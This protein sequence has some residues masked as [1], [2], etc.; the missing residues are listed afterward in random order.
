MKPFI[1]KVSYLIIIVALL[2]IS[3][4]MLLP[5][6]KNYNT[7]MIEKL[8]LLRKNKDKKK[9]LL[10][11]GSSVGWGLSAEQIQNATNTITINLGHH[12]GYGLTDFQDYILSC[13]TANDLIILSPEWV[14]YSDPYYSD[15]ATLGDLSRNNRYLEL[16]NR[17][18]IGRI[19]PILSKEISFI[20][21]PDKND[22]YRY[23]CLNGNGD[24]VSHCGLEAKGPR[25]Y[26]IDSLN[27]NPTKFANAFKYISSARCILL[28]PP[29][30]ES[31]YLKN[32]SKLNKLQRIITASNLHYL[33]SIT[34]NIYRESDFYDAEYHLNCE[35]R[36]KRTEKIISYIINQESTLQ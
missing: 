28:F 18:W 32:Q 15:K 9:I 10:I 30:Q 5:Q 25:K 22:P 17:P 6:K 24:V 31:V 21:Q 13:L 27:F 16:T 19:K 11:G 7:A 12:A 33:D 14:F 2:S 3:I 34:E 35:V 26:S 36:T 8:E 29:T 20:K 1:A 4:K 23:D